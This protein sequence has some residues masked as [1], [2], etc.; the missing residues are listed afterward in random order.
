MKFM[1]ILLFTLLLMASQ[2]GL[3]Q[4]VSVIRLLELEKLLEK[5]TDTTYVINFWATW[6]GPC[7]SELPGL[8]QLNAKYVR[9]K[10]K[11]ILV[12]MDFASQLETKVKPFVKKRGLKSEVYLLDE[13][14]YNAWIDKVDNNWSGAIPFTL[15]I[16]NQR[17]KRKSFEKELTYETLQAELQ[18]II[19]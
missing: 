15:I 4:E 10:V 5:T 17:R 9:S 7:V 19:Q 8:E 3:G 14:D 11:V 18:S 12:S 2:P 6:C 16:N 1:P 13:P